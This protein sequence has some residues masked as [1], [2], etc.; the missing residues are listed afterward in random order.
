MVPMAWKSLVVVSLM[1]TRLLRLI[2]KV[3][4]FSGVPSPTTVTVINAVPALTAKLTTPLVLP[5]KSEASVLTLARAQLAEAP[6]DKLPTRV[7]VNTSD[8]LASVSAMP[9]SA[10]LIQLLVWLRIVLTLPFTSP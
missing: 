2:W 7:T 6:T 10:M 4:S 3:S 8:W 1:L 9:L 5:V